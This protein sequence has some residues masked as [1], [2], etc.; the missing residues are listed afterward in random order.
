MMRS[1][2]LLA[3]LLPL[4]AR[5]EGAWEVN[6]IRLEPAQV[7][8]LADD[9]AAR[10]VD[11]VVANVARLELTP[12]QR[13]RMHAIYRETALDVYGRVIPVVK[14]RALDPEAKR[15][16]VRELVLEGQRRSHAELAAVLD[17]R[18]LEAYSAWERVQV[19]AFRSRRLDSR[20]RGSR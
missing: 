17:A 8:R 1:L 9:L 12:P 15:A 5:A 11:S 7:E 20:R 13:E 18:Q 6:G 2:W 14:D 16:R 4:A 10:T 3:A 19:D